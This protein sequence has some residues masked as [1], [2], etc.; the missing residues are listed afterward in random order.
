MMKTVVYCLLPLILA[1][2][3]THIVTAHSHLAL[4]STLLAFVMQ[5]ARLQVSPLHALG[6]QSLAH[7]GALEVVPMMMQI[8]S[9]IPSPLSLYG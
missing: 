6:I 7:S 8:Q 9:S 2:T 1:G 4:A 3:L 5:L